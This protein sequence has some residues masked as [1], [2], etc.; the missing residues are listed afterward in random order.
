[1]RLESPVCQIS[2]NTIKL[3][4]KYD[5]LVIVLTT[6]ILLPVTLQI[7]TKL[8]LSDFNEIVPVEKTVI[9]KAAVTC[10]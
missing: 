5:W 3:E 2:G 10:E 8:C 1:M 4:R 9:L 7:L 6:K